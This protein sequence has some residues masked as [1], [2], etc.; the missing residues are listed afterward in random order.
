VNVDQQVRDV[1]FARAWPV[2]DA[3]VDNALAQLGDQ[4]AGLEEFVD[5]PHRRRIAALA[6]AAALA[7]GIAIAV[8]T[9]A[10]AAGVAW[11]S[12]HTGL[13]GSK[14]QVENDESEF[15]RSD[16]PEMRAIIERNTRRY[17][18]PPDATWQ[19]AYDGVM[20]DE[21]IL[22]QE[23]VVAAVVA[24]TAAC[25]WEADWLKGAAAGD[26]DRVQAAITV[27]LDVPTWPDLAVT[28]PTGGLRRALRVVVHAAEQGNADLVR[29]DVAVNCGAA[30]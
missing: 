18:L 20:T 17:Q 19:P 8:P 16:S 29:A 10:A 3:G 27:L 6:G 24:R 12:V 14:G 7:A 22:V 5:R 28:D 21:T 9:G 25:A 26:R 4:L 2:G 30:R 15:L 11:V 1:G 13:F 23:R